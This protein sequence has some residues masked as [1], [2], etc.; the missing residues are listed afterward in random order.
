MRRSTQQ[1]SPASLI[2]ALAAN[3]KT[4]TMPGERAPAEANRISR[5]PRCQWRRRPLLGEET[6]ERR[7]ARSAARALATVN[8]LGPVI[9][10]AGTR[11]PAGASSSRI[12]VSAAA[13]S[14]PRGSNRAD[15]VPD[16]NGE[17]DLASDRPTNMETSASA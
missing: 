6:K 15:T 1:S 10:P 14:P 2:I 11:D 3:E 16:E 12:P 13:S 17:R 5:I 8:Q 7:P 9:T 4:R